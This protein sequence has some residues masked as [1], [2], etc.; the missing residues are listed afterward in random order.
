MAIPKSRTKGELI[1]AVIV[2]F[3]NGMMDYYW[4]K[5]QWNDIG[6]Y[7]GFLKSHSI[8]VLDIMKVHRRLLN[9]DDFLTDAWEG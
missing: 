3:R 9:A 1:S 8:S 6:G 7:Q 2:E 5:D 4:T